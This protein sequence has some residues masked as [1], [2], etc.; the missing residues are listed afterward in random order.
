MVIR[1]SQAGDSDYAAANDID[2][3]FNVLPFVVQDY[4]DARAD[5]PW[6]SWISGVSLTDL[7]HQLPK[8]NQYGDFIDETST[9]QLGS[10]NP[11]TITAS[12]SWVSSVMHYKVWID[13]NQNGVFEEGPETALYV[14]NLPRFLVHR[15]TLLLAILSY[16]PL[17]PA[18][19]HGCES[20]WQGMKSLLLVE[21][22]NW[23]K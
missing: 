22:T 10:T 9:M 21:H 17:Q 14:V 3:S 12:L 23:V 4:C 19:Q 2:R 18:A 11:I 1:A 5:K 13:Y 7:A 20:V 8:K 16:Q 15:L 6:N